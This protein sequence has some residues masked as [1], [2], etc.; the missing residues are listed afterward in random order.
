MGPTTR[1]MTA[2]SADSVLADRAVQAV[3]MC[4]L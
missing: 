3:V 4:V 1:V 2:P